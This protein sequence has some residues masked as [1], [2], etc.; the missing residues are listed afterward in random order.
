[1]VQWSNRI[2]IQY[3]EQ[4]KFICRKAAEV[5]RQLGDGNCRI[6]VCRREPREKAASVTL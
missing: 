1:M 6:Y 4:L 5:A 3:S 2:N